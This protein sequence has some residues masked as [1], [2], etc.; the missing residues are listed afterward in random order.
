MLYLLLSIVDGVHQLYFIGIDGLVMIATNPHGLVN[1]SPCNVVA[2]KTQGFNLYEQA[3]FMNK[4]QMT[5]VH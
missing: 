3:N 2:H 5:S 4:I 1:D